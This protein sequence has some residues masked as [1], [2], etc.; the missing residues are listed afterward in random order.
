MLRGTWCT[1]ELQKAV[2]KGYKILKIHEVWNF[3]EDQRKEGLFA[4]YVNTWLKHKTEASGWPAHCITEEEKAD[5]VRQYEVYEG[6]KLD[7]EKI[8]KNPG[9]KQV[10]KLML[11]SFWGKFGENEHHTQ[12]IAIQDEDVWQ[13]IVQDDSVVVK[14]VRIFNENVMEISTLKHEDACERS[15]KINIFIACFTTALA[16]LKLYAELEKLEGQ[17][18][19]Y[20][21]DSIIY[22]Y[23]EGEQLIPTGVFLGQ[24]TDELEGD[25]ITVFGSAGPKS[26]CYKTAKGKVECKNKGTKSSYEI[27][28]VLNCETMM[29]HIQQELS[30]P[31]A[32]RRVMEIEIKNHFVRDNKN[33]TVSLIDLVK[34]FGVN[35][36]KRV[37][38]KENL[39][40]WLCEVIMFSLD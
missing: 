18:L 34:V 38:E 19:Y 32:R 8:E 3:P 39:P 17:V 16:R 25:S 6:I 40:L 23:K 4:P 14:D 27:N 9:R 10:A 28:Q 35:W 1:P 20:D 24:M 29:S 30:D 31:L 36:D 5:Y 33:K 15:G 21:T 13:K 2:E 22:S 11:N 12:T 37:V 7:K 26:Y